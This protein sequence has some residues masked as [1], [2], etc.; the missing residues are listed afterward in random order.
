ML[1]ATAG[2]PPG[3]L[4]QHRGPADRARVAFER[5]RRGE[6]EQ[7]LLLLFIIVIQV[8]VIMMIRDTGGEVYHSNYHH[9]ITHIHM[10]YIYIY[11]YLSI[12]SSVHQRQTTEIASPWLPDR[13]RVASRDRDGEGQED[14]VDVGWLVGWS[15]WLSCL[16]CNDICY[17]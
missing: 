1:Q 11:I 7:I 4:L 6:G 3:G 13:A 15:S 2:S 9:R 12:S 14:R 5:R 10:H 8:L 16:S 17:S